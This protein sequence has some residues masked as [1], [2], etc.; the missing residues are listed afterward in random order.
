MLVKGATSSKHNSI[1][2]KQGIHFAYDVSIV[3]QVWW[4]FCYALIHILINWLQQ[5]LTS[6]MT[7]VLSWN[8]Q[9]LVDVPLVWNYGKTNFP[10]H[11][12]YNGNIVCETGPRDAFY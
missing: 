2:W 9:N 1:H 6:E 8:M 11:L 4:Q 12:K 10:L 5:I 7:A 3:T